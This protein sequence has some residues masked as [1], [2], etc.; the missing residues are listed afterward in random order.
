MLSNIGRRKS[1]DWLKN[2]LNDFHTVKIILMKEKC[3]KK[4]VQING[5]KI[6][7]IPDHQILSYGDLDPL[8]KVQKQLG[9]DILLSGILIILK[10]KSKIKNFR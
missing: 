4:L 5:F 6:G 10:L 9:C 8:T 7:M 3:L 1:Y 2:L